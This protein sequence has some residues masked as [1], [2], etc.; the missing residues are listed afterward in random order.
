[1]TQ[2]RRARRAAAG[3]TLI[4]AM[5]LV[6]VLLIG[7]TVAGMVLDRV[8]VRARTAEALAMLGEI[9]SREQALLAR[10]GTFLPLRADGRP[11]DDPP[12]EA[13]A[14]FYP[15]AADSPDLAATEAAGRLGDRASWPAG[16]RALGLQPR[17]GAVR[18]TYLANA[19]EGPVPP[20]LRFGS[21]LLAG[22]PPGRWFYALA[23]CNLAGRPGYPDEVTVFGVS[24]QSS[25]ISVFN[26]G[27]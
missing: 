2:S 10:V 20:D 16:W 14:A 13:A 8:V 23:A 22:A 15:L 17:P 12:D 3:F 21:A 27:R 25:R 18:C 7:G 6:A 1:V 26:D 24:S 19:G 11:A 9:S 4:E 5:V